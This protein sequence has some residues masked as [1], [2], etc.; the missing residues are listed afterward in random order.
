MILTEG[1]IKAQIRAIRKK[2]NPSVAAFALRSDGPWKGPPR[3]TIDGLPH[4]V[5]FC[6]SDLELRE[7][8]LGSSA[9]NDPLVA[10]CPF[11]N[12]SVGEDVLARLAKRRVHPQDAKETLGGLFLATSVDA[13]I[14]SKS[15]LPDALIENAPSDGYP[16]VAGGVLDL[17]TA[18]LELM[19]RM[20]GSREV[21]VNIGKLLE[22]TLDQNSRSRLERMSPDLRSEFFAWAAL[23]V[24]KSAA[25]MNHL[26]IANR[27]VDLIP[28]GL[29]L[30]LALDPASS[31]NPAVI[32]AR[33]RLESW[34]AGRTIDATSA[35]SWA[36]A[37]GAVI[38]SLHQR[39]SGSGSL[40]SSVL[41]RFDALLE[42]FKIGEVA[43]KSDLSPA[44]F[45]QRV[46][47]FANTL[48]RFA[49]PGAASN[50]D[51]KLIA[52]IESL[53]GHL[54]AK[55]QQRRIERCQMAARLAC[56]ISGGAKIANGP[57]FDEMV[58]GYARL[59]GFVDWA[60][61]IVQEGDTEPLL[62]KAYDAL[63]ARTQEIAGTFEADF[64]AKLAEWTK[65]GAT[66][67]STFVPVEH[68]LDRLVGPL[69]AKAP[70]LLLVM[71][72]MSVAVFRE[73][74]GDIIQRGNWL[75]CQPSEG[76][77]PT[78]LLATVPSITEVSRRAL[79]RG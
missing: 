69:A 62:N 20:V 2:A 14:F 76:F 25:W 4:R 11:S 9:E 77:I 36:D 68:A 79:F 38:Q 61:M 66:G 32:A 44:G 57:S 5:A 63:I 52:A 34:F 26:I 47:V 53:Q 12:E 19:G 51:A 7:L 64:A 35:R 71:D 13:R 78:A 29:L 28:L 75:E 59:G 31:A 33:V 45:E 49:R 67:G 30:G 18:W 55:E 17:Q 58:E 15:A 41:S 54:L 39:R 74:L 21:A 24:D 10:L 6:R 8:L 48:S 72:G 27:T 3:L 43:T 50:L 46:R 40:L 16:P 56:W 65:H 60:R 70:V 37:A 22:A 23:N 42:E 73:L 1:Q